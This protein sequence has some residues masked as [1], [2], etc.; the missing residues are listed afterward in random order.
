M[1]TGRSLDR[2]VVKAS[3]KCNP[4][5]GFI[6]VRNSPKRTNKLDQKARGDA[7]LSNYH[8]Y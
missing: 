2:K 8:L 3:G 6:G 5:T 4:K 7:F 1:T